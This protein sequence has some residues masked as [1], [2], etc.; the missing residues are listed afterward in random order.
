MSC[1]IRLIEHSDLAAIVAIQDSCYGNELFEDP[2]LITRRLMSQPNSCWLAQSH[3]AKVLAY[4]FSYPSR[5]KRVAP[6]GSEFQ[7][8][9]DADLLYLHDMAVSSAARGLGLASELLATAERYA[10]I[11]G[12]SKLALVA[13]QGSVPYWQKHGFGIVELT[14]G[15][16]LQAL[17]SYTAQSAVYM[18]KTL[19]S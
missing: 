7:R 15:S 16:A 17:Q 10:L 13:V 11:N 8:Y 14:E 19:F 6:L 4:L 9:N 5:E 3:D 18:Q 12:F 1:R 2:A